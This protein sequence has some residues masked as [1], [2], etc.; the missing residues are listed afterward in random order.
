[1]N[2]PGAGSGEPF[3]QAVTD[4]LVS[5]ECGRETSATEAVFSLELIVDRRAQDAFATIRA[6]L[7]PDAAG[8]EHGEARAFEH[9]FLDPLKGPIT[10]AGFSLAVNNGDGPVCVTVRDFRIYGLTPGRRGTRLL[11]TIRQRLVR[12]LFTSLPGAH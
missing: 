11:G 12:W 7:V 1:M 6:R 10:A 8:R 5:S 4:W 2:T 9:S 3:P